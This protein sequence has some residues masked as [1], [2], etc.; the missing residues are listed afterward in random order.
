MDVVVKTKIYSWKYKCL[1]SVCVVW[2]WLF[3]RYSSFLTGYIFPLSRLFHHR[4][5][6]EYRVIPELLLRQRNTMKSEANYL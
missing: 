6:T 1:G 5:Q 3:I 2:E 4:V